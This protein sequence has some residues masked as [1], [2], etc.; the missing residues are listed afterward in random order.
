MP[1][2]KKKTTKK[3]SKKRGRILHYCP[4]CEKWRGSDE[5]CPECGSETIEKELPLGRGNWYFI[6]GV[7][8]PLLRVTQILKVINKPA[9]E[10]WKQKQVAKAVFE[11]PLM[12]MEQALGAKFKKGDKAMKRGGDIHKVIEYIANGKKVIEEAV[13]ALPEYE[14][15]KKFENLFPF[16]FEG[17]ELVVYDEELGVA[18][19]L[20]AKIR[21]YSDIMISGKKAFESAKKQGFKKV[22]KFGKM[23][24]MRKFGKKGI[25][26]WKTGAGL[27]PTYDIQLSV[28]KHLYEKMNPKEKID[29][30]FLVLLKKDGT[31]EI[32]VVKDQYDTFLHFLGLYKW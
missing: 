11:N 10:I 3:R 13:S 28:Y 14:A 7:E 17:A 16:K 22:K 30:M 1:R 32:K 8:K 26:D 9:L 31:P 21:T 6:E 4:K 12:S 25:I 23:I 29:F 18:G 20:D 5:T 15:F 27:Y 19:T 2:K 24:K